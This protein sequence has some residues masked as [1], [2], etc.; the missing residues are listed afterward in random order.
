MAWHDTWREMRGAKINGMSISEVLKSLKASGYEASEWK[1][2]RCIKAGH[3]SRPNRHYGAFRFTE[4]HMNQ[5]RAFFES[6]RAKC[7]TN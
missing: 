1:V 2:R 5:L 6:R 7:A 4:D 3:C